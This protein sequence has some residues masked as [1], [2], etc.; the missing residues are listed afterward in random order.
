MIFTIIKIGSKIE[1]HEKTER[2]LRKLGQPF[3]VLEIHKNPTVAHQRFE[4]IT[5]QHKP[6]PTP[7]PKRHHTEKTKRKISKANRGKNNPMYGPISDERRKAI[8]KGMIGNQ[9]RRGKK[10]S[11]VQSAKQS[12]AQKRGWIKRRNKQIPKK[13]WCHNVHTGKEHLV[14]AT[15]ILPQGYQWGRSEEVLEITQYGY[16]KYVD[17]KYVDRQRGT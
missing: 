16:E 1:L 3:E 17:E 8:S 6:K 7:K 9:N 5:Q 11:K 14:P 2:E 10:L 4:Q 13:R 12:I 15:T